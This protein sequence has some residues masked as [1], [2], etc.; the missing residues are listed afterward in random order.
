MSHFGNNLNIIISYLGAFFFSCV[1]TVTEKIPGSFAGFEYKKNATQIYSEAS[2]YLVASTL[3]VQ[4]FVDDYRLKIIYVILTILIIELI[5]SR[6]L[7]NRDTLILRGK[8]KT[9]NRKQEDSARVKEFVLNKEKLLKNFQD[10]YNTQQTMRASIEDMVS[11]C[12]EIIDLGKTLQEDRKSL[13]DNRYGYL[14]KKL[15]DIEEI[16]VCGE[17]NDADYLSYDSEDWNM[18]LLN[19]KAIQMELPDVS[20]GSRGA[21]AFAIRSAELLN[22]IVAIVQP[23]YPDGYE[24]QEMVEED[25]ENDE[26]ESDEDESDEDESDEDENNE[27]ESDPDWV[28][29]SDDEDDEICLP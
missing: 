19:E 13:V 26:D 12:T 29:S 3:K 18:Y 25:S 14:E 15:N 5:G 7:L 8:E 21:L 2:I 28:P 27:D 10:Q 24:T 9:F 17:Y 22:K 1:D 23:V 11:H 6:I 4:Q 20:W 16:M